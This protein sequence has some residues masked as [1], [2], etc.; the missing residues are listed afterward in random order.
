MKNKSTLTLVSELNGINFT[1][2]AK[3]EKNIFLK[4]ITKLGLVLMMFMVSPAAFAMQIFV[5]TLTGKTIALE[6]EPSD[7]IE[8]VKAKIQDKEGIPPDQQRLIFAGKQLEDG[9]TL[10][11]YNI[12]KESTLHLV[13][14]LRANPSTDTSTQDQLTMQSYAAQR[15]TASQV[16]NITDHFQLLHQNFNVR[17][18]GLALN[19]SNP[20]LSSLTSL[21]DGSA[22]SNNSPVRFVPRESI[23]NPI[24]LAENTVESAIQPQIMNDSD[25]TKADYAESFN[26]RLFG[27]LPIGLWATGTLDYGSID[28][29]GGN[30]KFSSQGITLGIDYQVANSLII[31]A[32]LGYGFDKTDIDDFGSKTKSHQTTGSIYGSYK[33]LPH[34]YVDGVLGY[35]N[36][37]FDNRRWSATDSLYLS[38]NRDGNVTFGSLGL[39]TFIQAQQ[40]SLQPYLRANIAS[41]KLDNYS[42]SGSINALTYDNSKITSKTVTTGLNTFYDIKLESGTLT[43]LLKVQYTHNFDGDMS[44]NMFVS[45]LG[46]GSQNY[47]LSTNS[48][49]QNFGSLGLGLRYISHKNFSADLAY[50]ASSGSSSYHANALRFDVN[51]GF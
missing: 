10:S 5:K 19:S 22:S 49:P 48:T 2:S 45:N 47:N 33:V 29:Q 32:A 25:V 18:N 44:Q 38:G 41:I 23:R 4:S 13:L 35:G 46:A 27:H 11:D 17:N 9:R 36:T 3:P 42:E 8:N 34:W 50:T 31:G 51:L 21:F 16:N 40:L 37:A 43:P 7:S 39:S 14:R 12:Q 15:F 20:V 24:V 6:V 30:N 26:Q 1:S 28:G